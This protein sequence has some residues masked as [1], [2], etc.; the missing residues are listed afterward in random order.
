MGK[1]AVQNVLEIIR[2]S[3]QRPEMRQVNTG[4]T[5]HERGSSMPAHNTCPIPPI[6]PKTK[7]VQPAEA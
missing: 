3:G 1:W 2:G 4:F 7:Q 6:F 5:I